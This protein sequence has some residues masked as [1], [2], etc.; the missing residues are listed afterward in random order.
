MLKFLKHAAAPAIITAAAFA[1]SPASAQS[2]P[3]GL[4][5]DDTG[6]A[7]IEITDCGGKLCG[8][9]VWFKNP[10][11]N[12]GCNMQIIGDVKPVSGGKWDKGWIRDPEND[13]KYDVEIAPGGEGKLKVTGYLGTKLFGKTLVWTRAP[14]DLKR[15]SVRSAERTPPAAEPPAPTAPPPAVEP[16]AATPSTPPP[17]EP[18]ARPRVE[19]PKAAPP[20]A[21]RAPGPAPAPEPKRKTAKQ[22]CKLEFGGFKLTLPCDD[23]D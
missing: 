6:R 20:P 8:S 12:E 23:D 3:F 11:D 10:K 9:M 14:A 21:E 1:T 2:S 5:I 19:A 16:P 22:D 15:C 13:S 18:E 4:W 17:A 7:A